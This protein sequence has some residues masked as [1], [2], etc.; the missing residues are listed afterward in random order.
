MDSV[1]TLEQ[2]L[3]RTMES[4]VSSHAAVSGGLN[5]F[6][7]S[8]NDSANLINPRDAYIG[9]D[10][11]PW[12][13]VGLSGPTGD[14]TVI[15][16]HEAELDRVR[17]LARWFSDENCFAA[18]SHNNRINYVV[19]WGHTYNVVARPNEEVSDDEL[20]RVK[21]TLEE[22][23]RVNRWSP[24]YVLGSRGASGRHGWGY[25]QHSNVLRRDRDG[26]VFLRKFRAGDGILRVRYVEPE[27]VRTPS[28]THANVRFGI[29]TEPGDEETVVAYW[30]DGQP[31]EAQEIQHRTR[32]G[33]ARH[34]RGVPIHYAVRKN[35]VRADKILRNGS[36]VTEIQTAIGM[37]RKHL[38]ATQA[39]VQ[40]FQQGLTTARNA[41]NDE[42]RRQQYKPGSILDASANIEYEFPGMKIDP[43]KYVAALQAELRAIA[44]RLTM[45]EFMLTSDASNSNFASTMVAE[46]PAVKNFEWLQWDEIASDLELIWDALQFA[47]DS[48]RINPNLLELIDVTAEPSPVQAR[49]RIEDAQV[50]QI[51][52]GL[53]WLSPQ[54]GAAQFGLDYEQEQANIDVD[55]ERRGLPLSDDRPPLPPVPGDPGDDEETDPVV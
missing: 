22:F 17:S 26:E 7:E 33:S 39:T 15:Y 32:E 34:P 18:N 31:V 23:L 2:T 44:S 25:R 52:D 1:Q 40:A 51:L 9:P 46:G 47:A 48:G 30:I 12:I 16:Q 29:Q 43:G 10:G 28:S 24:S 13:P 19:G 6:L 50:A 21:E 36:T 4:L 42:P 37:I 3:V 14:Q 54:T 11:E 35:L 20:G 5:R 55:R 27:H 49:N 38:Q 8:W 45:P 53:G 41:T